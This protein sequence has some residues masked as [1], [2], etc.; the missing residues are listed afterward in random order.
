[1]YSVAFGGK[2]GKREWVLGTGRDL[3][4]GQLTLGKRPAGMVIC[5][6]GRKAA[7]PS[8]GSFLA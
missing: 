4:M 3:K 7:V 2:R 6:Q 5:N 8:K 1:M